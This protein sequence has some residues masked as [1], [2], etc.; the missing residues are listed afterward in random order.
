MDMVPRAN[1]FYY[2]RE[3][4]I[5]MYSAMF[6]LNKIISSLREIDKEKINEILPQVMRLESEADEIKHHILEKELPESSEMNRFI[7]L[8]ET[9]DEIMDEIEEIGKLLDIKGCDN[10]HADILDKLKEL[11]NYTLDSTNF[12]VEILE[13]FQ[14]EGVPVK[15][16]FEK[17]N[18]YITKLS[19]EEINLLKTV[20]DYKDELNAFHLSKIV[21]SFGKI[22]ACIK[23]TAENLKNMYGI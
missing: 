16:T 22:N 23:E 9:Q 6:E 14:G 21:T 18:E 5:K 4:A 20:Y 11:S 17:L 8:V 3:H 1:E 13:T 12:L 19:E 2:L 10:V 7:N 15:E